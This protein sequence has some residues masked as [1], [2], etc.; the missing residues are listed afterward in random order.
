VQKKKVEE[1]EAAEKDE[2]EK[3]KEENDE[4]EEEKKKY[5]NRSSC[6]FLAFPPQQTK[7]VRP[8]VHGLLLTI[9]PKCRIFMKFGTGIIYKTSSSKREFSKIGL[10]TVTL[11]LRS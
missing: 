7:S 8:S 2:E 6:L 5:W 4:E 9:K 11:Y 1:E 3:R 10:V